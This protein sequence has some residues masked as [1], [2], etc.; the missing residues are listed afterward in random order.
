MPEA[1]NKRLSNISSDKKLSIQA[2]PPYQ[3]ALQKSGYNFKLQYNR[4]NLNH[5]EVENNVIWFNPP[6]NSTISTNIGC[7]FLQAVGDS[8]TPDHPLRK[9]FNRNT[10]KLSYS[11]I[12]N[13]KSIISSHN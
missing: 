5:P 12:P 1:I 10:L 7:K 2:V 13:V 3:E 11:C 4:Q 9:I 8:F 6:N